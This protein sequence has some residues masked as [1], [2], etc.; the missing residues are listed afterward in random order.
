MNYRLIPPAASGGAVVL[1]RKY[2][3]Q[4]FL[5]I[6]LLVLGVPVFLSGLL[7]LLAD[8]GDMHGSVLWTG[9]GLFLLS[10]GVLVFTQVQYPDTFTFDNGLGALVIAEKG[11][12]GATACVPYADIAGFRVRAHRQ[13]NG[14]MHAVEMEKRDGACWAFL[15][16]RGEQ[17]AREA[18]DLLSRGVNLDAASVPLPAAEEAPGGISVADRGGVKIITWKKSQSFTGFVAGYALISGFAMAIFGS[19]PMVEKNRFAYFIAAGFAAVV[20]IMALVNLVYA[21]RRRY[22]VE[23]GNGLFRYYTTGLALKGL[24][25]SRPLT[26]I[27]SILFNFSVR[28]G[29]TTLHVLSREER[30]K[31]LAVTRGEVALGD[32][33][34]SVSF[35]AR[36]PRVD[37]GHLGV[38]GKLRL[39]KII[40]DAVRDKTDR[41]GL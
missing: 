16:F 14:V 19:G 38:P 39:E 40:Q 12:R 23:V 4:R 20:V 7:F 30:E 15:F 37:T 28:R 36:V 22:V 34:A 11:R 33:I 27:D 3:L 18:C 31:L 1:K 13:D 35:M 6:T 5:G 41:E 29:E 10:A 9:I 26:E 8:E 21:V 32:I 24:S 2:G 17:G 25:F